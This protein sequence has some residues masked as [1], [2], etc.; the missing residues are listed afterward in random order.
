VK[1]GKLL[2]FARDP[3]PGQAKTR[4]IPALGEKAAATLHARLTR[5]TLA[6]ACSVEG[7]CVNLYCTPDSKT[8]FFRQCREDFPLDLHLQQG[9]D[10]GQRMQQAFLSALK[11]TDQAILIGTDC[12]ELTAEDLRQARAIL[13]Q[14]D[15][16][17]GPAHD[18]GY[19]LLGLKQ[20]AP[21]LFCDIPWGGNQ[22]AQLTRAR[23]RELG[24]TCQELR[25]LHDLDREEDLLRFRQ[26]RTL[27]SLFPDP[28]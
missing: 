23:I 7:F 6:S 8:P 9:A 16:V 1:Q 21:Q 22:V 13:E 24:W 5:R 2:I 17:L 26:I 20:A 10:L 4:L 28:R 19:Y 12:P 14:H 25:L 27:K 15:C 18:G 11:D 3:V